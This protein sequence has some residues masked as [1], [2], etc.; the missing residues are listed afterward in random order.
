[1]YKAWEN[2]NEVLVKYLIEQG[3][4]INKKYNHNIISMY[5]AWENGNEVL[6]KYFVEH[7]AYK[8][9]VNLLRKLHYFMHVKMKI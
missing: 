8:D 2:G 4:D 9:N 5:K 1:M 7:S 6:I 3:A